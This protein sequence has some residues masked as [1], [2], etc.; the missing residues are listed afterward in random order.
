MGDQQALTR[1][2]F[3]EILD[4]ELIS[5]NSCKSWQDEEANP[6][7]AF[8]GVLFGSLIGTSLAAFGVLVGWSWLTSVA[9]LLLVGPL[10]AVACIAI[11]VT[12]LQ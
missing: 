8:A 4:Q 2:E 6:P 11:A 1:I 7:I 12:K 10:I 5:R 3:E 9:C